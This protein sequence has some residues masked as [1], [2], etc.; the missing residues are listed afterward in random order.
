MPVLS[1]WRYL[2]HCQNI[3]CYL[4]N[5]VRDKRQEIIK[6]KW[7]KVFAKMSSEVDTAWLTRVYH[8]LL[9]WGWKLV[10]V[11]FGVREHGTWNMEHTWNGFVRFSFSENEETL[12][13]YYCTY[14]VIR[15]RILI[16]TFD[17]AKAIIRTIIKL[18]V[19]IYREDALAPRL[20]YFYTFQ[21]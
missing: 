13:C 6:D 19:V 3:V 15:D 16:R 9:V 21:F 5:G 11:F 4:S 14:H 18:S 7:M 8:K 12:S 20:N 10:Q 17:H 1:L 2:R